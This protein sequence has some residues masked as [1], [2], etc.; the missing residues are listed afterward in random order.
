MHVY[1]TVANE[2]ESKNLKEVKE[3][4]MVNIGRRKGKCEMI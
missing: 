1:V 2:K 4:Y 3:W